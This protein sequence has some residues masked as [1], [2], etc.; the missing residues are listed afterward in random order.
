MDERSDQV[1]EGGIRERAQSGDEVAQSRIEIERTRADMGETVDAIQQRLSPENVKEQAKT[2]AKQGARDAGSGLVETIKQNP[3]PVA[4]IGAGL[5]WL[6]WSAG[7]GGSSSG[8]SYGSYGG[9]SGSSS[10][11]QAR[12]QQATGQAQERASQMTGQ[13]QEKA[14]QAGEQA[15]QQAQRAKSGFQQTLQESP[16]AL[17]ALAFGVGAAFGFSMP[18]SRK[19]DELMGEKRDQLANQAQQKIDETQQRAQRVAEQARSTAEEEANRQD[20]SSES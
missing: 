6:A 17:G 13:A 15:Q 4:M 14:S 8:G 20:L 3:V 11:Q 2:Q 18:G 19:E 7:S 16:L 1:R 9:N 12:A 5:G 10:T